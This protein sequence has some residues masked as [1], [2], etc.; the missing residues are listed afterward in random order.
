M[1]GLNFKT[2]F[3]LVYLDFIDCLVATNFVRM[4]QEQNRNLT[5]TPDLKIDPALMTSLKSK[6]YDPMVYVSLYV[7]DLLG[8]L[9]S[10]M[11]QDWDPVL[12]ESK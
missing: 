8:V 3:P 12:K 4:V 5:Y 11:T 2:A 10:E 7:F 9:D 6:M 1:T